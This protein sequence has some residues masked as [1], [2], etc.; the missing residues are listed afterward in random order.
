MDTV[1]DLPKNVC[2]ICKK[3]EATRLCDFVMSSWQYCGHP[4]KNTNE[5]MSGV[6]TCDVMMCDKCSKRFGETDL[7]DKHYKAIKGG[8]GNG[9]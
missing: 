3:R 1:I 6:N 9:I 7:C 8:V 4:P 2:Q 5:K